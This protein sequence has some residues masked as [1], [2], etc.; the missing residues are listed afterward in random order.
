MLAKILEHD[1]QAIANLVAHRAADVDPAGFGQRFH[2]RGD[3]D[4]VAVDQIAVRDHIAHVDREAKLDAP[5]GRRI[6]APL[7]HCP[8]DRDR[9]AHGIDD[10]V[11]LDQQA[12]AHR[13]HDA[14]P[15]L[16]DLRVDEIVADRSE[17]RQGALL[18]DPH[19]P[20]IADD[21]GAQNDGKPMLYSGICHNLPASPRLSTHLSSVVRGHPR[22]AASRGVSV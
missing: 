6:G 1:R 21:I 13:A 4:T 20:G 18:V 10:A 15:V 8:L 3:G 14:A 7:R 17:R 16:G 12:V 19:Q 5:V 9:A 22:Q 11:E 2:P